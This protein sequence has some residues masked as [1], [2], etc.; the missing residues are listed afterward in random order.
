MPEVNQ[1]YQKYQISLLR[2]KAGPHGSQRKLMTET[3]G[4]RL[5]SLPRYLE[6]LRHDYKQQKRERNDGVPRLAWY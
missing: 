1:K 3:I 6:C 4:P 2:I 5:S